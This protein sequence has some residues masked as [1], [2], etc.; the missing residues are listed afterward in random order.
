MNECGTFLVLEHVHEGVH[1]LV[2]YMYMNMNMN[3]NMIHKLEY[4]Y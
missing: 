3:T 1:V 2:M 4:E